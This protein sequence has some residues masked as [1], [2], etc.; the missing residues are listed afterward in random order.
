M[1]LATAQ[2][3]K[4]TKAASWCFTRWWCFTA[5]WANIRCILYLFCQVMTIWVYIVCVYVC[6][7]VCPV[8]QLHA[9]VLV[10]GPH[11]KTGGVSSSTAASAL[12][13]KPLSLM[14][15]RLQRKQFIQ[16]CWQASLQHCTAQQQHCG[17]LLLIPGVSMNMNTLR[18]LEPMWQ[19]S[20]I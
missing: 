3:G 10:E 1:E 4:C 13:L 5:K 11:M 19:R 16:S 18:T 14:M 2:S 6:M 8:Q 17:L 15:A 20:S 7:Y 12:L 9:A